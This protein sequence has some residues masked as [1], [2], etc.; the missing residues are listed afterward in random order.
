MGTMN[1]MRQWVKVEL[2]VVSQLDHEWQADTVAVLWKQDPALQ[3][4]G[5]WHT[6]PGGGTTLSSLD[7]QALR[8]I[9][10]APDARQPNPL[11]LVVAL[12]PDRA[13]LRATV[14]SSDRLKPLRI[15]VQIG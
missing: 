7:I 11:M 5:D 3:Y 2:I 14:L 8:T 9:A 15:A 4:L 13:R 10:T 12:H 6:H 1:S